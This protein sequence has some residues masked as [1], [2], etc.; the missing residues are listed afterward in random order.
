MSDA[1][2][3]WTYEFYQTACGLRVDGNPARGDD[4]A[5]LADLGRVSTPPIGAVPLISLRLKFSHSARAALCD[6]AYRISG[7]F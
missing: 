6:N 2:L 1:A 3:A 5:L 4:A 7:Y